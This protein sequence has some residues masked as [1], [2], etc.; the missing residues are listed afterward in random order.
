MWY[1]DSI[2]ENPFQV[3]KHALGW[4]LSI[5]R[6]IDVGMQ[7]LQNGFNPG[8]AE[9]VSQDQERP[10]FS[11]GGT[12]TRSAPLFIYRLNSCCITTCAPRGASGG[13][14]QRH[15][16]RIWSMPCVNTQFSTSAN[17]K[18]QCVAIVPAYSVCVELPA[19]LWCA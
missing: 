17:C 10:K 1:L 11:A 15:R 19:S 8:N 2:I 7:V 12:A 6:F 4:C 9:N 13:C 3:A 16:A 18:W 5:F 14:W